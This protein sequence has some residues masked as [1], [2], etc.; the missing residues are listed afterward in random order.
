MKSGKRPELPVE[1]APVNDDPADAR[2]VAA[3][4]FR[5]ALDDNVC[6]VLDGTAQRRRSR[7][8]V[9]NER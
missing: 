2:S 3:D 5:G 4:E 1:V 7:G 8:V 9:N 6:T